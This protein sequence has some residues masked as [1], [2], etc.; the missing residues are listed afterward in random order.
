MAV[1]RE[2]G[3]ADHTKSTGHEQF[4]ETIYGLVC[5]ACHNYILID[6]TNCPFTCREHEPCRQAYS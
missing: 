3:R 4:S 6:K 1:P 2:Q 5:A